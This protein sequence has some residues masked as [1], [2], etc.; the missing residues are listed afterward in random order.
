MEILVDLLGASDTIGGVEIG[1]PGALGK[2]WIS[3]SKSW[4]ISTIESSETGEEGKGSRK[5]GGR[6]G[7]L[8][9]GIKGE[10]VDSI[11]E[12]KG[13]TLSWNTTSLEMKKECDWRSN[14]LYPLMLKG[15]P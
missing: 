12:A 13:K 6:V 5:T 8:G 15:Y 10:G 1:M 7:I 3:L 11:F 2:S 4:W 14:S 9:K